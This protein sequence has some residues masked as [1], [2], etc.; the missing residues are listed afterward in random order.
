MVV[1]GAGTAGA[2]PRRHEDEQKECAG[3]ARH[4]GFRQPSYR[5]AQTEKS[6]T[7]TYGHL[8]AQMSASSTPFEALRSLPPRSKG[9]GPQNPTR[10]STRWIPQRN[11]GKSSVVRKPVRVAGSHGQ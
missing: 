8:R 6:R 5:T 2:P 1:G 3:H 10:S 4:E 9:R 11:T 7:T